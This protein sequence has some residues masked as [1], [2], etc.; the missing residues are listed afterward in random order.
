MRI[1]YRVPIFTVVII[2][3]ALGCTIN[4]GGP[5]YPNYR[6]PFS[7]QAVKQMADGIETSVSDGMESGEITIVISESQLTS[8]VTVELQNQ[9]I[10]IITDPQ[11]YLRENHIELYGTVHKGYWEATANILLEPKIDDQG[12][13]TFEIISAD[14]G[15][16]PA[17]EGVID[18]ISNVIT[19]AYT[20]SIGPIAT[21]IRIRTVIIS[22]GAMMIIGNI[23]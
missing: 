5:E 15:P 17:P 10:S 7:T 16:F 20:G 9:P 2:L 21:G 11:V 4:I 22:D 13:L 6:I 12:D 1:H 19:E 3:T 18:T 8:F 23:K 14:F